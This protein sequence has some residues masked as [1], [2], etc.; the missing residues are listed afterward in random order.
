M[1]CG[2]FIKIGVSK[3]PDKREKQIPYKVMQYYSSKPID[4]PFEVERKMHTHFRKYS[5]V[6]IGKE[7]FHL[8]FTDAV[9]KLMKMTKEINYENEKQVID[10]LKVY[11]V[12][13]DGEE[14]TERRITEK[15]K[16]VISSLSEFD[17]GYFLAKYY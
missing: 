16:D 3:D 13:G 12:G 8:P 14:E 4:N 9:S 2:S 10:R 7:Y 6:S 5:A 1:D 17:K 11:A 15:V